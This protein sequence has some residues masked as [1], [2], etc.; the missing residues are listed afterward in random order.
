MRLRAYPIHRSR[1]ARAQAPLP[2]SGNTL[3]PRDCF[4]N[5]WLERIPLDSATCE[6]PTERPTFRLEPGSPI[7]VRGQL[8]GVHTLTTFVA[9][10]LCSLDGFDA[11]EAANPTAEEHQAF[12]DLLARS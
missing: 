11:N 6:K 12:N 7:P 9:S 4:H 8:Q 10:I 1:M 2:A 3:S 5:T